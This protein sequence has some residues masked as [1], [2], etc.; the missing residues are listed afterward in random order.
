[1]ELVFTS[2]VG[3]NS[4]LIAHV[5]AMYL[6]PM[7]NVADVTY[8]KGVFWRKV[9]ITKYNMRFSDLITGPNKDDF[10]KLPLPDAT[11]DC[12]VLDPPYTHN[13]GHLIV[14]A[15]YQNAETTKGM[16]HADIMRLYSE[17]MAEAW[18]ILKVGGYLWV[19]CKDEI[20]SSYQCWSHIEIY[21][22]ARRIG[23]FGMDLFIMTQKAKPIVQHRKQQHA[24]K[25]HSYLWI[26]KKPM[27]RESRDIRR[28]ARTQKP[29]PK[30]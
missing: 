30:P 23:F 19:K 8:G 25:N 9:D 7:D 15:N 24:R 29:A 14:N 17:G 2:E 1:M 6:K 5:A 13:P 28:L 3:D 16:Y 22:E 12:V 20:E 11:Y 18:R 10:R 21:D 27:I 26:F 4:D